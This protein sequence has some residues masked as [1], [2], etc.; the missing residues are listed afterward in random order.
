MLSSKIDATSQKLEQLKVNSISSSTPFASC[1]ICGSVNHLI[2]TCQVGSPFAPDISESVNYVNNFNSRPT[3]DLFSN[4]YNPNWRNLLNFFYR[5][6]GSSMPQINFR[7]P[8]RFE[9]P[10]QTPQKQT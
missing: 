7:P 2:V 5:S 8:P 9:K 1:E 6:G 10:Q 4:T 3:N